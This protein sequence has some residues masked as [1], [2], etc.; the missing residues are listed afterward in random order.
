MIAGYGVRTSDERCPAIHPIECR[1]Y[2]TDVFFNQ[3]MRWIQ[4]AKGR[5]PFFA[6][7]TPNAPHAP[8]VVAE[9]YEKMYAD[10][11]PAA[12]AKFFGMIANLDENVGKLLAMLKEEG[13][14]R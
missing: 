10:K 6:M 3:A 14:E 12:T 9:Q 1:G 5:Q 13:L 2:C 11:V 7:I 4:T 8:L